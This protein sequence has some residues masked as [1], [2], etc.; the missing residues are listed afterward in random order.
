MYPGCSLSRRSGGLEHNQGRSLS[1]F[2]APCRT[3]HTYHLQRET[4]ICSSDIVF[5]CHDRDLLPFFVV[6]SNRWCARRGDLG[7]LTQGVGCTIGDQ[8]MSVAN[9]RGL[10][11][12]IQLLLFEVFAWVCQVHNSGKYR[13]RDFKQPVAILLVH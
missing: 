12:V 4:L 5:I 13:L 3:L 7:D 1:Y 10:H 9:F 11:L 2:P 8:L 6:I